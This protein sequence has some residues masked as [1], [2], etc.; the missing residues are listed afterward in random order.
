MKL[1]KDDRVV[2][3]LSLREIK[4]Y[5]L[6]GYTYNKIETKVNEVT[7]EEDDNEDDE[8]VVEEVIEEV[9]APKKG[10]TK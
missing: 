10:K 1:Y 6:K 4:E 7:T 8:E 2:N 5:L 9:K 3:A